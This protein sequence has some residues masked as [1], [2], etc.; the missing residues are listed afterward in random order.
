MDS[1]RRGSDPAVPLSV[2]AFVFAALVFLSGLGAWPLIDPDEGRNAEVARELLGA[3][4]GWVPTFNGLAYLDKPIAYFRAVA[5]SY[6]MF[7]VSE[8]AAR[9]PTAICALL[10]AALFYR[11]CR[12][13]Y[14]PRVAALAVFVLASTPLV[15]AFARIVIFDL[16]LTLFVATA[17]LLGF[18]A[19]RSEG[20]R[21]RI[22]SL[23][24]AAAAGC[25]TLI[26]GP[27][28]FLLPGLV[29]LAHGWL[30]PRLLGRPRR[31]SPFSLAA[32]LVFFGVTLPWFIG[33][34]LAQPDFPQY[35]LVEETFRRY[36]TTAFHRTAPFWYY[37][38]VLLG[39][40]FPWSALLPDGVFRAWQLRRRLE[41]SDLLFAI[42]ALVV[43]VFF[44]TSRSKLPGYILPGVVALAPLAAR[45]FVA[46]MDNRSGVASLMVRRGTV[47]LGSLTLVGGAFLLANALAP[48]VTR[49]TFRIHGSEFHRFR[50][51]FLPMGS[52]FLVASL[53]SFFAL[54]GRRAGILFGVFTLL[55][56][57][58]VA[59]GW[60]GFRESIAEA[61]TF[62]LV[63]EMELDPDTRVACLECFPPGLPFY[64]RHPVTLVSR[65]G[66]EMTSNYV[67]FA[68]RE[69]GGIPTPSAPDVPSADDA[70]DT[71]DVREEKQFAEGRIVRV[72]DLGAWLDSSPAPAYLIAKRKG[73]ARLDSLALS[74]G[75]TVVELKRG[76]WGVG[77]PGAEARLSMTP[78]PAAAV[79]TEE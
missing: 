50:P 19:E 52:V 45:V 46:A 40:F 7:G 23:C 66:R 12:R 75:S 18:E 57:L 63:Q 1:A 22:L 4:L 43:V 5:L 76:W 38:P 79:E 48:E 3:P 36:S 16:P 59:A 62:S 20:G 74:H 53:V 61:S 56:V 68:L 14:S 65:D 2:A 31:G 30:T 73:H 51:V 64:L 29:L 37:G 34:S 42:W 55:P 25:A 44:S 21:R 41:E 49:E 69:Q 60:S 10:L 6:S 8:A 70:R 47:V 17:I 77:L 32:V 15:L 27:V 54:R 67:L 28:G 9:V 33:L 24:G 72:S 58:A 26:K 11:F 13:H 35:G 71:H 39:V 78:I